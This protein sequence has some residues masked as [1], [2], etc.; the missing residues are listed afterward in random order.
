MMPQPEARRLRLLVI[1]H[2][3]APDVCGGG[4]IFS[5]MCYGLAQRDIDVTV[6]CAYP[7]YPEWKD[8]SGRNGIRIECAF[9]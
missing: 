7:Y 9:R 4:S 1:S 3:F 2:L 6:R 8:K 5:D